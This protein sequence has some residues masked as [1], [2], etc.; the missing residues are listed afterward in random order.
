MKL[1]ITW[2]SLLFLLL[3]IFAGCGA[4]G[5][6]NIAAMTVQKGRFEII[7]PAFGELQAVTSTPITVPTTVRGS[8]T[9]AWIAPENSIVKKGETVIRM[10]AAWYKE[11]IQKEEFSI[12][13]LNLQIGEKEKELG[14]EKKDLQGQL[15]VTEI[16]KEL[17]ALYAAKDETI[18][19]RNE[20]IEDAIN[21]EYLKTKTRHFEQKK[22]Q[23]EQKSIAELQLLQLKRKTHQVKLKQYRDALDSLEVKA[24]HDGLFIYEKNWRGEKPRVGM[25]VWRGMKLAKLPDLS[26]MEA[27]VYVLESEAAGLKADLPVSIFLDSSPGMVFPGKV[28]NIDTIAKPLER[29]SPLKYFEIKVGIDKI[30]KEIMKPG[31]QVKASVF[32]QEQDNVITV[33][34]QALFFDD[35]DAFVNIKRSSNVEKREVKIGARSLTQTVITDGLA[36]GEEVVLGNPMQ[37]YE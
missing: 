29:D 26:R 2:Y 31:S 22:E 32:V 23:L 14:K 6:K 28:T 19:S 36:E 9:I 37:E 35:G 21:L 11:R 12:T 20:I 8:Q 10:D 1:K 30:E 27:K 24:P 15:I 5:K 7:I 13:K 16:E 18:F 3:F 34:N 4:S 33:P 17:A 25:S